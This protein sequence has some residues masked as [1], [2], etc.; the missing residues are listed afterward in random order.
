MQ[1]EEGSRKRRR[2][3]KC[4]SVPLS[5]HS[6]ASPFITF[7]RTH[8]RTQAC[9]CVCGCAGKAPG[10]VKGPSSVSLLAMWRMKSRLRRKEQIRRVTLIEQASRRCWDFGLAL[11]PPAR[12]A[13]GRARWK[14]KNNRPCDRLSPPFFNGLRLS[15]S[16][17]IEE[18]GRGRRKR[19]AWRGRD[20]PRQQHPGSREASLGGWAPV[21]IMRKDK[22]QGKGISL[23]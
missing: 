2:Q 8:A 16:P 5:F 18:L 11:P 22:L 20:A 13:I 15:K 12:P 21:Q 14:G 19:S 9:V 3:S 7:A 10:A 4:M 17:G 6:H 23:R 1:E